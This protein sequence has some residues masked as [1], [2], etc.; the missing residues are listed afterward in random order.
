MLAGGKAQRFGSDKA[1]A[2]I[3]GKRL[4]DRVAASLSGQ[5]DALV[6]CGR[7]DPE[8]TCIADRPEPGLG[9]LGGLCAA[10][11]YAQTH[12]FKAVLS[13]GCDALNLPESLAEH[14]SGDG[15]GV[16][17]SQPV[18]GYWPSSLARDLD[19]FIAGGGRALYGFAEHVGA[20]LERFDPPIANV[21]RP[22]DLV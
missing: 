3:G 8:F 14:L 7:E 13:S 22:E 16:V 18:I 4:I 10:L 6:V 9:P 1:E 19:A 12:S 2:R 11:H 15:P 5:T 20:R 21:N 17:Q